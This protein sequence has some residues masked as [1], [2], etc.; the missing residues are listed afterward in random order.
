MALSNKIYQNVN[1][2]CQAQ[3]CNTFNL[4]NWYTISLTTNVDTITPNIKE[5]AGLSIFK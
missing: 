3:A 1:Q 2:H 5:V 4:Y